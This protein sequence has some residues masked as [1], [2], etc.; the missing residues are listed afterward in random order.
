MSAARETR[1]TTHAFSDR[2]DYR[3]FAAAVAYCSG[4]PGFTN[5]V[6]D[7]SWYNVTNAYMPVRLVVSNE[8][9][10]AW[11]R[12][13]IASNHFTSVELGLT[14]FPWL[15]WTIHDCAY[16]STP[17]RGIVTGETE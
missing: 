2:P 14:N 7:Y 10:Y 4:P 1:P 6:G 5:T 3:I 12:M 17:S 16:E 15:T 11:I 8:N 13:S 9:H